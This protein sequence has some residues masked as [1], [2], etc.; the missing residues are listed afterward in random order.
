MISVDFR[1]YGKSHI[2]WLP[3]NLKVT[4]TLRQD[5]TKSDFSIIIDGLSFIKLPFHFL[6]RI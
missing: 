5:V 4:D 6:C 1:N 3:Q 2:L